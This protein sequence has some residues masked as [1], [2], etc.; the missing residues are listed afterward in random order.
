MRIAALFDGLVEGEMPLAGGGGAARGVSGVFQGLLK[1]ENL[2][3]SPTFKTQ[4]LLLAP[5]TS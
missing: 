2:T 3:K 5:L 1:G 4:P